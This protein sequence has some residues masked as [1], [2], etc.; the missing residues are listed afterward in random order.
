MILPMR[1]ILI[2]GTKSTI[3]FF[4]SLFR[5]SPTK[6]VGENKSVIS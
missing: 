4:N 6:R 5:D 2:F 1:I 3:H